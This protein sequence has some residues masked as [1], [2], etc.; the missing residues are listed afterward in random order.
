MLTLLR[1]DPLEEFSLF[2]DSGIKKISE[3]DRLATNSG[4]VGGLLLLFPSVGQCNF[5]I[6]LDINESAV[7]LIYVD[8]NSHEGDRN[9]VFNKEIESRLGA[10]LEISGNQY[11]AWVRI[12]DNRS[13]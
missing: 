11:K 3:L 2:E 5:V 9:L 7:S 12:H 10:I 4:V 1:P 8:G 6:P 13:G